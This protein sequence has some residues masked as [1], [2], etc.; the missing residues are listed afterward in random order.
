MYLRCHQVV[1]R[2]SLTRQTIYRLVAEGKFPRPVHLA[3]R[4]PRWLA[5][6]VDKYLRDRL[7]ERDRAA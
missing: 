2:T 4:S 3:E 1:A 6:E 5:E 7:A